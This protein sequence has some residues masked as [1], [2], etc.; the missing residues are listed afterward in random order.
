[1]IKTRDRDEADKSE[2]DKGHDDPLR[3]L[4]LGKRAPP[5]IRRVNSAGPPFIR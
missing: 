5:L 2:R 4:L 1:M 3:R